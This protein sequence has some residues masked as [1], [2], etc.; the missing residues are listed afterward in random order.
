MSVRVIVVCVVCDDDLEISV[1]GVENRM[2]Y[3][4]RCDEFSEYDCFYISFV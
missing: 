3:V 4:N 1:K 2:L